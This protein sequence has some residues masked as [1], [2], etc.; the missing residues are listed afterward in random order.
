MTQ[1]KQTRND[2]PLLTDYGKRG[3]KAP[4]FIAGYLPL[5]RP[6]QSRLNTTTAAIEP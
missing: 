2:P 6:G 4:F 1:R 3:R 5:R